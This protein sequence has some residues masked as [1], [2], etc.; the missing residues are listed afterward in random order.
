MGPVA[1]D[2]RDRCQRSM[3]VSNANN[4]MGGEVDTASPDS[5]RGSFGVGICFLF[6]SFALEQKTRSDPSS[7]L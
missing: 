6:P 2:V 4:G 7:Q 1:R 5:R 3:G